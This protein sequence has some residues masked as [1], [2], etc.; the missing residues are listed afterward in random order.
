MDGFVWLRHPEHGG[1]A[2]FAE[3]AAPQWQAMGWEPCDP[4][5]EDEANQGQAKPEL[6]ASKQ[7]TTT[8]APKE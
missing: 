1:V 4:P 3:G 6:A 7:K 5:D 8:R 2:A